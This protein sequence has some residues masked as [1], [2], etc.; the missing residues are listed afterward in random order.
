M[1][2]VEGHASRTPRMNVRKLK[3]PKCGRTVKDYANGTQTSIDSGPVLPPL[4]GRK[5]EPVV[6]RTETGHNL[7]RMVKF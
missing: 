2:G 3:W 4:R 1:G 5:I 7:R 6:P